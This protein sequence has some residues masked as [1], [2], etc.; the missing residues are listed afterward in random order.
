MNLTAVSRLYNIDHELL[1]QAHWNILLV[2]YSNEVS[3]LFWLTLWC[4]CVS[5]QELFTAECKFKESVFENY[6]VIYSSMLYRQQ[7]S[8]RAWFL[9]LNKEGQA[10]KGNR[11][12]KTKPAAHFL[13]KPLEGESLGFSHHKTIQLQ[14]AN[15]LVYPV[16]TVEMIY[17]RKLIYE[18]PF[19]SVPV[20]WKCV[21]ILEPTAGADLFQRFTSFV[22][23]RLLFQSPCT[24][25]PRC[26][27]LE[28]Q[29]PRRLRRPVKA[30][31]SP[32][33]WME[34]N[35]SASPTNPPH[36]HTWPVP[37]AFP[38]LFLGLI[39]SFSSCLRMDWWNLR[40]LTDRSTGGKRT[41]EHGMPSNSSETER[42]S[43]TSTC[44]TTTLEVAFCL[45][46]VHPRNLP[47]LCNALL[48]QSLCNL[49]IYFL[50]HSSPAMFWDRDCID[51]V[52][53]WTVVLYFLQVSPPS[54]LSNCIH[55][56]LFVKLLRRGFARTPSDFL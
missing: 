30:Q 42:I 25:S 5:L 53:I 49:Q 9:G 45:L 17:S 29:Y 46:M 38:L 51:R 44:F 8:G 22:L 37:S 33:S 34:V 14:S 36:S 48:Q 41:F 28:R 10:M 56:F 6:Y 12:K 47:P 43:V 1:I 18:V 23:D 35:L 15:L 32:Q 19:S 40:Q 24:E 39:L 3:Y 31:V 27:T 2:R 16:V 20:L 50:Y 52:N 4:L 54:P 13:P 11:V 26:T 55:T 7:E 21:N